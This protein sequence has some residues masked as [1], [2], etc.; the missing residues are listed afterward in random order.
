MRSTEEAPT[1]RSSS[2]LT[3]YNMMASVGSLDIS[4]DLGCLR[5]GG[6]IAP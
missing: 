2:R 1:T 6:C 3:A 4:A 5:R